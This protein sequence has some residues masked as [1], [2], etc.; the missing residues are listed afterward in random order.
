MS[1]DIE[2]SVKCNSKSKYLGKG[3]RPGKRVYIFYTAGYSKL[4]LSKAFESRLA[5]SAKIGIESIP[6][7]DFLSNLVRSTLCFMAANT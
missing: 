1:D 3:R 4:L 6:D 5:S 7:G 2:Y